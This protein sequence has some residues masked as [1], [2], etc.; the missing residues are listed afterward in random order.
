MAKALRWSVLP[1]AN[2]GCGGW[3]RDNLV[4]ATSALG[5][6]QGPHTVSD[7]VHT[8]MP[9]SAQEALP[10]ALADQSGGGVTEALNAGTLSAR[11][12]S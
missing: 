11:P 9:R 10:Y 6:T 5:P 2:S 4:T 8:Y 12:A 7:G 3:R 1:R